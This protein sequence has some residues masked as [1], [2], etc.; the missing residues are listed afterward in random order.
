[1]RFVWVAA[2]ALCAGTL[3]AQDA[4][5]GFS[6]PLTLSGGAMYTHR[7]Q[8]GEPENLPGTAGFRVTAYPTLKL[9]SHWF[10]YAAVQLR[11]APYFYYDAYE[12]DHEFY[13]DVLQV[14]LGYSFRVGDAS[15]VVKAGRLSSAFGSFP[16]RYDDAENPLLDQPLPYVTQLPLSAS[17]LPCGAGGFAG[18]GYRAGLSTCAATAGQQDGLTPVT[19]YGLYGVEADYSAHRL[20]GRIQVTSGSP[21]NAQKVAQAGQYAQWTLGGGYTIRQGF[22]VGVSGFRGPYLNEVLAPL[23]PLGTTPRDFPASGVGVDVQW[24]RGRWSATGEWQRFGFDIPNFTR[25]PRLTTGYGEVKSVLTP[26]FY[27]AGRVGWLKSGEV[28]DKWGGS[29][30]EFTSDMASYEIAGGCWLNRHQLL[31]LGY[32]WLHVEGQASTQN[33]VLGI[34]LVTSFNKLSWAFR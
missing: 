32:E 28:T 15:V 10:A 8:S 21:A 13:S 16:L 31:K 11:L 24:A 5:Y 2:G 19:L 26:R 6:V 30:D 12:A 34:Q 14:F 1:M 17:Q 23:L 9:G 25:S 22:R 7:L 3:A 33:K 27:L 4:N 20:D 18:G 29:A